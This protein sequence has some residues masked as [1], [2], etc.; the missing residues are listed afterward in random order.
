M[1]DIFVDLIK[2]EN[3]SGYDNPLYF[4]E[5]VATLA[6]IIALGTLA[7]IIEQNPGAT[8]IIDND[9]WYLE[10]ITPPEYDELNEEQKRYWVDTQATLATSL[11]FPQLGCCF[12]YGLLQAM[13]L[14][15]NITVEQV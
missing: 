14:I 2:Q 11:D 8:A 3:A 15:C 4:E 7:G 6:K 13:A 10:A 12:G 1:S 5:E 9:V